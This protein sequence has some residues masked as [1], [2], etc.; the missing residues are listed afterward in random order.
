MRRTGLT[1][2]ER[3][4]ARL[5]GRNLSNDEIAR[6]LGI[7]RGTVKNHVH[8]ILLKRGLPPRAR[9]SSKRGGITAAGRKRIGDAQ[10]RRWKRWRRKAEGA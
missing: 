4:V 8:N 7:T 1:P 9:G 2:R 3:E 5:V 6:R 10:R